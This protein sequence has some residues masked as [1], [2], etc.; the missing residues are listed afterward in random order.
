MEVV[1]VATVGKSLSMKECAMAI[2]ELYWVGRRTTDSS[3]A[4][5]IPCAPKEIWFEIARHGQCVG[6]R[7]PISHKNSIMNR[8]AIVIPNHPG[9]TPSPITD[10][11]H[12]LVC[13]SCK[14]VCLDPIVPPCGDHH[15]RACATA[16][17][18][19]GNANCTVC[20]APWR[21]DEWQGLEDQRHRGV[22]NV[23]EK[24]QVTCISC[25]SVEL[26]GYKGDEF[27]AH[28]QK[29][30]LQ[31]PACDALTS[32][33]QIKTHLDDDCPNL[34]IHCSAADVGCDAKE[35][36]SAMWDAH[37]ESCQL[38]YLA[39][40]LRD[41]AKLRANIANLQK[42]EIEAIQ[43]EKRQMAAIATI[44]KA[45]NESNAK[46]TALSNEV[47][48]LR[49]ALAENSTVQLRTEL[50]ELR[51]TIAKLNEMAGVRAAPPKAAATPSPAPAAKAAPAPAPAPAAA[52]PKG[53]K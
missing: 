44:E 37:E 13:P 17:V 45:L 50:G 3:E 1:E 40:A 14:L 34:I 43:R 27:Q 39:P 7:F 12:G 36:R 42:G 35:K 47:A 4:L 48:E 41:V 23:Y 21:Q 20:K 46:V 28:I 8:E 49:K 2:A 15:C 6:A 52:V 16:S 29:C 11:F 10:L 30:P 33:A 5:A 25:N 32:R 24:I 38:L 22:R 26:R 19:Q 18:K 53:G 31:C 9:Y 51:A